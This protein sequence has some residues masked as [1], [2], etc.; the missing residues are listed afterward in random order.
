MC[1]VCDNLLLIYYL[2]WRT[3]NLGC[4]DSSVGIKKKSMPH[5]DLSLNPLNPHKT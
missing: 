4:G 3:S 5:K 1:L 2:L